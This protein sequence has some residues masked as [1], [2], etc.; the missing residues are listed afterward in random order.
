M[1]KPRLITERQKR[2]LE[3]VTAYEQKHGRS[4][5]IREIMDGTG[6]SS[7]SVVTYNLD[8]LEDRKL[9]SRERA[10][11]RGIKLAVLPGPTNPDDLYP[12]LTLDEANAIK[13]FIA[14]HFPTACPLIQAHG[15]GLAVLVVAR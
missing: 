11:A 5:V 1:Y 3:F 15:D 9:I 7:S 12:P 4:P 10:I 14:R 6:I 2:V 13:L 8:R